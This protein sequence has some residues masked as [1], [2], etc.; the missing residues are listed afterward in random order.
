VFQISSGFRNNL[1]LNN[2]T[3]DHLT[4][5]TKHPLKNT[6]LVGVAPVNPR[7]PFNITFTNNVVPAAKYAVWS[8]GAGQCVK[9]GDPAAT[10]KQCWTGSK[11]T[12]NAIV[13]YDGSADWSPGNFYPKNFKEIGFRSLCSAEAIG[14]FRLQPSS[15]FAG[16]GTDV[17]DIGADMVAIEKAIAGVR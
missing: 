2:V 5:V 15:R 4:V 14:G 12:R 10:F 13:G 1:P 9:N 17:K 16:K 8:T 3:I 7:K 6:V 11:V